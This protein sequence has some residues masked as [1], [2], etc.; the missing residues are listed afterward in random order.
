MSASHAGLAAASFR[1]ASQHVPMRSPVDLLELP[2][3][4]TQLRP[5]M[6]HQFVAEVRGRGVMLTEAQVEALHR[7]RLV[8]PF[9]RVQRDTRLIQK[10]V[11]EASPYARQVADWQPTNR[12]D[13]DEARQGGL[14][15]DPAR[16]RFFSHAAR[17]RSA[18]PFEYLSSDY[19]YSHHQL[20]A[21]PTIKGVRQ[22]LRIKRGTQGREAE[23]DVDRRWL[24]VAKDHTDKLR[25]IA[26]AISA[27]E[28]R[29]FPRLLPGP[30]LFPEDEYRQFD[31]W[32]RQLPL[33]ATTKWLGVKPTWFKDAGA[34]LLD[35][36]DGFDPL[37]DWL[38]V[39]GA[40]DP[41]R[42]KD[43]KGDARNAMDHRIAAELLLRYYEDLATGR[44]AKPLPRP[45]DRWGTP[46]RFRLQQHGNVDQLL[47]DFGL[48]PHPSLLL[49]VEGPGEANLLPRVIRMFAVRTDRDFIAIENMEGVHRDLDS[50]VAYAVGPQTEVSDHGR[51][52]EPMRPL[53]RILVVTD[54]EGPMGTAAQREKKRQDWVKR[55]SRVLPPEHRTDVTYEAL[56]SL[57]HI[58][59]WNRRGDSFEFAHFTDRQIA[60]AITVV[61]SEG[62]LSL[63]V[64][65]RAVAGVRSSHG[66][67]KK[68]IGRRSKVALADELWPVLEK[69][70]RRA[71]RQ[72]TMTRIPIVR[73]LV[74]ATG[75]ARELRRAHVV[76]PLHPRGGTPS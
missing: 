71:E 21:I 38:E 36:A 51:Y 14:L 65:I 48:S 57:V 46:F 47:T 7:V 43:L 35:I 13:L 18:G 39:V 42:W 8:T 52:L 75:I 68:F 61:N 45:T 44:R 55:L 28:A 16:E 26:V 27:L 15:R 70:I 69:K 34:L 25:D 9:L 40:G 31:R 73:V 59:T 3:T 37:G 67:L 63:P 29:Y 41:G 20:L 4:F 32:W 76:I 33:L 30:N 50:L 49:V 64:L 22:W 56:D 19:L 62:Q 58:D 12:R 6:S 2:Y 5:L 17:E 74:R 53:T 24:A 23:L 72:K 66:N 1:A 10:L 11:R 54:A 60:Q